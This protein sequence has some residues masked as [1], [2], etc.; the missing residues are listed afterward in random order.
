MAHYVVTESS[1]DGSFRVVTGVAFT[2]VPGGSNQAGV[3]WVDVMRAYRVYRNRRNGT[4]TEAEIPV[5]PGVQAQ[6]DAGTLFEWRW[7]A[8][9]PTAHT[10]PQAIAAIEL[11]I[12]TLEA[13]EITRL[14]EIL[15]YWGFEDDS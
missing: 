11:A 5:A 3:D 6:L 9:F 8:T 14:S 10:N 4:T 15:R 13:A 7:V 12:N 2:A 1:I